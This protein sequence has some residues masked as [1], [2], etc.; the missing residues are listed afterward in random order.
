MHTQDTRIDR[1]T[2]TANGHRDSGG[3]R[4]RENIRSLACALAAAALGLSF[5]AVAQVDSDS[6][7]VQI[8]EIIVTAQKREAAAQDTSLSLTVM[9]EDM[10]ETAGIVSS[11][12]LADSVPNLLVVD[13]GGGFNQIE[14]RGIA[15]QSNSIQTASTIGTYID[16][17]PVSTSGGIVPDI[18]LFDSQRIE[19][20][21]GPQ[22]T[23]FG[24]G[25][26]S[27][28]MRIISNKPDPTAFSARLQGR[29]SS[30]DGGDT[31]YGFRGLLNIPLVEDSLA[32]RLVAGTRE[33]DGWYDNLRTGDKNTN[34]ESVTNVR[35]T[36]SWLPSEALSV[37]LV[38]AYS[39]SDVGDNFAGIT[40]DTK[41]SYVPEIRESEVN[42]TSLTISYDFGNVELVSATAVYDQKGLTRTDVSEL[43]IFL[44]QV[45]LGRTITAGWSDRTFDYEG[46]SQELRLASTGDGPFSWTVG[47][48]YRED[49]RNF[50][51]SGLGTPA[52]PFDTFESRFPIENESYA[53]F[54]EASYQFN[55]QFN[56]LA[57]LRYFDTSRS[58]QFDI[59]GAFIAPPGVVLSGT[60]EGSDDEVSPKVALTWT[61]NDNVLLYAMMASGF[62]AGG[63]VP[64]AP[65]VPIF[66][67]GLTIEDTFGPETMVNYELGAKTMLL[68]NRL[69]LNVY[70][71]Q[72]E[73]EDIQLIGI[74]FSTLLDYFYNGGKA[75]SK[76][77][78]VELQ[79]QLTDRL[80]VGAGAAFLNAELTETIV[81]PL[82]GEIL[83]DGNKL[84]RSPDF[85]FNANINYAYPVTDR[86]DGTFH[87][88]YTYTDES[89]S[90]AT[91]DPALKNDSASV[92]N[93]RVG[94]AGD[95]FGIYA[96]ADNL[97]NEEQTFSSFV[98]D[99][100]AIASNYRRPRTIGL[101]FTADF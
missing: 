21:R 89:F 96:F 71:F 9:S 50:T 23:L 56:L 13:N 19:I 2:E 29:G 54:G 41:D 94:L 45:I 90:T 55:D 87:A 25:S 60:S 46:I 85:S 17:I 36:L 1:S 65:L 28:T 34:D 98:R 53:F 69:M 3:C 43:A 59:F 70:V 57:G 33:S 14:I 44:N 58:A 92:V 86:M 38:Y 91:N 84:P 31:N 49:D 97:T 88:S 18:A 79:A 61:P 48:F 93:L 76:G 99:T 73:W 62:R 7:T 64:T 80:R 63:A 10:L 95:R 26:L 32:L 40:V 30:T 4:Q 83:P 74:D 77:V 12:E 81:D 66:N 22:G 51:F 52:A 75:E 101:E 82:T 67:G 8:E 16:E 100:G 20:L 6:G 78:E 5:P 39:D 27:G 72:M 37:D 24:D 15:D 47:G 35:G 42:A 68:D 11:V